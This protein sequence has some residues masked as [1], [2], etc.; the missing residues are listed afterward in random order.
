MRAY[1]ASRWGIVLLVIATLTLFLASEGAQSQKRKKENEVNYQT[2]FR[3]SVDIVVVK[4]TVT[5][6]A[7]NPVTDLTA[8]DFRIFDD[9]KE[10][11]IQTFALE[12]YGSAQ[13]EELP[14]SS[15]KKRSAE[16]G[17]TGGRLISIVVDDLTMA[18]PSDFNY[19]IEGLKQFVKNDIGPNDMV[20]FLSGS[21]NVQLPFT[22]DKP[23]FLEQLPIA[24]KKLNF[25]AIN[26]STCPKL[27]DLKAWW[28]SNITH[29]FRIDYRS[30]I[31]ETIGY[32]NLN[33]SRQEG[34]S[35]A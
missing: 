11:P 26:R 8:D 19:M 32:L 7:G 22:D 31:R 18:H 21:G 2:T 23:Q 33:S 24:L 1:T 3:Q 9:G 29:D 25:A 17:T 10:Q 12:S 27:S 30:L 16:V 28:I 34:D 13:S 35:G 6:K 4:A 20:A 15:S 5:D 14:A